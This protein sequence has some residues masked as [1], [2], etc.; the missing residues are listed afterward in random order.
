VEK[1]QVGQKAGVIA[2]A[3]Q[4]EIDKAGI[5]VPTPLLG[6]GIGIFC[7]EPPY[8][9]P[10]SNAVI[11]EN[12]VISLE[13]LVHIPGGLGAPVEDTYLVT[14]SGAQRLSIDDQ[15]LFVVK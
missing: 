3:W 8:I 5:F 14:A 13:S 7:N 10:G 12:M 1:L 2:D 9:V 15:S 4:D 11:R 6:H